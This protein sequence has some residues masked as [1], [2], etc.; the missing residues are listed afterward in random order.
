MP[1]R[2]WFQ[3]HLLQPQLAAPPLEGV[4]TRY[5]RCPRATSL[6]AVGSIRS[7][8]EGLSV[9]TEGL[10]LVAATIAAWPFT[11]RATGNL[12]ALLTSLVGLGAAIV[13]GDFGPGMAMAIVGPALFVRSRAKKIIKPA[14]LDVFREAVF[15]LTGFGLYELGRIAAGELRQGCNRQRSQRRVVRAKNRNILR[16]RVPSVHKPERRHRTRPQLRLLPRVPVDVSCSPGLDV[17]GRS[18]AL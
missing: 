9:H 6:L 3:R 15:L 1:A 4:A 8:S 12:V 5:W 18:A 11:R 17:R 2:Q 16:A 14:N 13:F 7:V 10:A